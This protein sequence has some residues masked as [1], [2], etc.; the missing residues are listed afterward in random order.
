MTYGDLNSVEIVKKNPMLYP[1]F[2][3]LNHFI[4]LR[5][6]LANQLVRKGLSR[7]TKPNRKFTKIYSE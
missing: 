4:S 1:F 3:D 7:N 6:S 2:K 5:E